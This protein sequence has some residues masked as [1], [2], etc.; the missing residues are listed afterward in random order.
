MT[1]LL[2][3]PALCVALVMVV[4]ALGWLLVFGLF[5]YDEIKRHRKP[6]VNLVAYR[7]L[8]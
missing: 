8:D 2:I 1:W 3:V 4:V 5:L 6:S 7:V